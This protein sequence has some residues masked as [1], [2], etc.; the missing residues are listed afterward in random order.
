MDPIKHAK[1]LNDPNF[2]FGVGT[3]SY[4]I[5]GAHDVGGRT[6]SIWDTFCREPGRIKNADTGDHACDHYHRFEE[7]LDIIA[8]LNVDVY[9]FSISWSRW[10]KPDGSKNPE[11]VEFYKKLIAGLHERNVKPVVTLYHWDL[12]QWLDDKGGWLNRATCHAFVEYTE[13]VVSELGE[14]ISS[15]TTLNE[16]WCSSILS[17]FIGDHAPGHKSRKEAY[18]AA[19]HLLVAHGLSCTKIRELAPHAE[20]SIVLDGGLAMPKTDSAAD[21]EAANLSN[22]ES[23]GLFLDPLFKK[24]YPKMLSTAFPDAVPV[25]EDGD[26]DII[27]APLDFLGWNYYTCNIIFAIDT[28]GLDLDKEQPYSSIKIPDVGTTDMGWSIYPEGLTQ[29]LCSLT[30]DYDTLPPVYITE[31]G[32]A[33]PDEVVDGAVNDDIRLTYLDNHLEA[34]QKANDLGCNIRGYYYWSLMDNFEWAYGLEKRFGLTHV[35]YKTQKRTL[36]KSGHA[37]AKLLSNKVKRA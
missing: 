1:L 26:L 3:S 16:P 28:D 5:E 24:Q 37:Y 19:H 27:S 14:S 29:T 33:W 17:Y 8:S 35:D 4:Q 30:E 2:L 34:V 22:A 20:V 10:L 21:I 13:S 32:M 11:G 12:P 7:D 15:Y 18:Q 9:R 23:Y 25:R 36:K 31:N 6:P